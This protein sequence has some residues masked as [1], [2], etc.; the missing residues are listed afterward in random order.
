MVK[1]QRELVLNVT[2]PHGAV[3]EREGE[4]ERKVWI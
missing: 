1:G 2:Y 4:R 3:N